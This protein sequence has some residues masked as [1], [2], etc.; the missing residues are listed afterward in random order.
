VSNSIAPAVL[1]VRD[2]TT[3][4]NLTPAGVT[5]DA[6]TNTATF[7]FVAPLAD[8]NYRATVLASA[9]TDPSGNALNGGA[10]YTFDFYWLRGDIDRD[11]SV[12]FADLLILAQNYGR[13]RR[14]AQG[15][16]NDEHM[17][18]FADLLILVQGYGTTCRWRQRHGRRVRFTFNERFCH[19]RSRL[20]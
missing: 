8:G 19:P 20:Q 7:S 13:P 10:D 5:Y 14:Y 4:A 11:R 18:D 6:A 12:D 15:D 17:V 1:N 2:L 3:G 9:L 16:L